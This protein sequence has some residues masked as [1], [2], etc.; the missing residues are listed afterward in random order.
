MCATSNRINAGYGFLTRVGPRFVRYGGRRVVMNTTGEQAIDI[1]YIQNADERE[2]VYVATVLPQIVGDRV[3]LV[4]DD[5]SLD[6]LIASL[7]DARS[8]INDE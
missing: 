7:Q 3:Y 2:V 6:T 1:V 5:E 4:V 8:L